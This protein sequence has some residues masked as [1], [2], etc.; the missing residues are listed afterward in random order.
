MCHTVSQLL[1]KC[2]VCVTIKE[3]MGL[4]CSSHISRYLIRKY[5]FNWVLWIY[6]SG[7]WLAVHQG[8]VDAR[9]QF[10]ETPPSISSLQSRKL[11]CPRCHCARGLPCLGHTTDF[12]IKFILLL[13]LL[14]TTG[15]KQWF[16]ILENSMNAE[17]KFVVYTLRI[18]ILFLLN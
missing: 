12:F 3:L 17:I 10:L 8:P 5:G 11:Q 16:C 14:H 18:L 2:L 6:R 15:S 9:N 4:I 7:G 1:E 13:L